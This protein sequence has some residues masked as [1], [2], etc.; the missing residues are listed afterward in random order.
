VSSAAEKDLYMIY[1]KSPLPRK[2]RN[3]L[4]LRGIS[5]GLEKAGAVEVMY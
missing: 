4:R 2:K 1:R 5:R 3:P